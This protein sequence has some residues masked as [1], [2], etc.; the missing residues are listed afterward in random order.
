MR[1]WIRSESLNTVLYL[2]LDCFVQLWQDGKLAGNG[3][4]CWWSAV[5]SV[6]SFVVSFV[7]HHFVDTSWYSFD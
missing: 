3:L 1:S 7:Y 4:D 5:G 2:G 6:A